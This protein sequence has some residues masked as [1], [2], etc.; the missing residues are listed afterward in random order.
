M[1]TAIET[2]VPRPIMQCALGP[3]WERL[4]DVVRRHYDVT[5]GTE[6]AVVMQGTMTVHHSTLAY[7]VLLVGRAI[8]ALIAK[9]G[10]GVAV[11]VRN[12]CRPDSPAMHWH[13]TFRFPG[14]AP[15]VF[16][17]RM[18]YLENDEIVEYVRFNLG[19]RMRLSEEKGALVFTS[20]GYQWDLGAFC[21]RLPDWLFLGKAEIREIP[22]DRERFRVEFRMRHPLLGETFGYHGEFSLL[23]SESALPGNG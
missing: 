17:S 19:V 2:P 12:W 10:N 3:D 18:E 1:E 15:T 13:R 6:D 21:L 16:A 23:F 22:I 8:G 20:R 11:R 5:P 14:S 7:P 9:R 4:G